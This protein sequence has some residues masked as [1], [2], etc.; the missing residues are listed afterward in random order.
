METLSPIYKKSPSSILSPNLN[1]TGLGGKYFK[2]LA[3]LT[4]VLGQKWVYIIV[5]AIESH[6]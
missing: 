1:K 4:Y 2:I 5:T 6:G 3:I